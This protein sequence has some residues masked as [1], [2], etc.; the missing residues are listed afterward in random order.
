MNPISRL[1]RPTFTYFCCTFLCSVSVL[2]QSEPALFFTDRGTNK[3]YRAG[4]DGK[5]PKVLAEFR[6]ANLRGIAHDVPNGRVYFNDNGSDRIYSMKVD[7]S[8]L[9][10]IV[11]V[12]GFP[13]DLDYD[14]KGKKL[15]WCNQQE[16]RIRRCNT[17]GSKVETVVET[18][19]PY[20][21]EVDEANGVLYWGTF[22]KGGAI[23][24]RKLAGGK[25]DTLIAAPAAGII[26]IRAVKVDAKKNQIYWVDREAHKIQRG[27]ISNGKIDLGTIEDLYT[28]LDTPHGMV[29]DLEGEKNLLG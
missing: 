13:A 8:D 3:V 22:Y 23:Y 29:L 1:I 18:R 5:N 9:K 20:Y 21:L 28:G 26:Q 2:A 19:Q 17:D 27:T 25:T 10:P 15:Y 7:G 12:R 4:L 14:A 24:R 6:F 16:S 11:S